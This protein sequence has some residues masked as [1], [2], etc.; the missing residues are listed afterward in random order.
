MDRKTQSLSGTA[1][2]QKDH[3]AESVVMLT[4][5]FETFGLLNAPA[6]MDM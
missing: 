3:F 1:A 2:L 5:L 4:F 6:D